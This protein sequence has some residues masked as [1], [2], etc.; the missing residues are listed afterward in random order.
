M[1]HVET[2]GNVFLFF[3]FLSHI[4]TSPHYLLF[5]YVIATLAYPLAVQRPSD[6]HLTSN[7]ACGDQKSTAVLTD[8]HCPSCCQNC[9]LKTTSTKRSLYCGCVRGGRSLPQRCTGDRCHALSFLSHGQSI[10]LA[11]QQQACPCSAH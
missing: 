3:S 9:A 8:H 11:R 7:K 10:S 5:F 4:C 1:S 6:F 2:S